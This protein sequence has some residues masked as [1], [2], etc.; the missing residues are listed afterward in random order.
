MPRIVI[1][2]PP[3]NDSE[4][5]IEW[6]EFKGLGVRSYEYTFEHTSQNGSNEWST[7]VTAAK[8]IVAQDERNKKEPL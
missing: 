4:L 7:L 8:A 1:T 5:Y 3:E 6:K 2:Y